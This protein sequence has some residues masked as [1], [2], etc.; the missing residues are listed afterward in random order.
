[1]LLSDR[2]VRNVPVTVDLY[3]DVVF[4]NNFTMD[5]LLLVILRRIMKLEK[6]R[7]GILLSSMAGGGYALAVTIYPFPRALLQTVVTYVLV[8]SIMVWVAFPVK[9]RRELLKVVLGLYLTTVIMAGIFNLFPVHGISWYAEQ[10]I[11]RSGFKEIPFYVYIPAAAGCFLLT[12]FLWEAV[13]TA[14]H[15]NG[16]LFSV[17]VFYQGRSQ[18]MI[19]FLDTGNRL[20]E[21]YSHN[22]VSIISADCCTELF[23]T[24]TNLLY[25]PYHS[26]GKKEGILPAVKADRM[27]IEKQG[28]IVIVE[29]PVIA[30]SKVALSPDNSY[31]MLLNEKI[32]S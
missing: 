1:M 17:V 14:E 19:A 32:W 8:S 3:A 4:F 24:V 18:S 6:R 15:D 28:R 11:F 12:L 31:Q 29:Q 10:L 25:I 22:P 27:E 9:S 30:I 13:K 20:T 23:H 16:H 5:F 21:P 2:E 7:G 26:V